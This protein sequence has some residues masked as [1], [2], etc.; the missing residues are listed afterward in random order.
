MWVLTALYFT[1]ASIGYYF[2]YRKGRQ[3]KDP[4]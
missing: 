2:Q 1:I 3:Q 4:A